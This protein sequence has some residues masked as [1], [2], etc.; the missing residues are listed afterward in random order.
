MDEACARF[1]VERV[2]CVHRVGDLAIGEVAVWA[3]AAAGHRAA[4]FEACR[5]VI[6]EVKARVPI[7]KRE[8]YREGQSEWL[9]PGAG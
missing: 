8:H 3:A 9:H 2:A 5:Y 4:A 7:W 1:A 6:D